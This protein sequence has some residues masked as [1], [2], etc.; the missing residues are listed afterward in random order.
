MPVYE[1]RC[2]ACGRTFDELRPM[3]AAPPEACPACGAP[4]VRRVYGRVGV[5]FGGWGFASTD[6]L[7]PESRRRGKDFKA[8][9]RKADEI[10]GG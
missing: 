8:L 6:A 10:A 4:G 9:Q 1:Y 5:R 7:L 2:Q 3:G